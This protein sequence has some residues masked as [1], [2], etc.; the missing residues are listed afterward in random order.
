ML[1]V[2]WWNVAGGVANCRRSAFLASPA[3]GISHWGK[4]A[5]QVRTFFQTC[6]VWGCDVRHFGWS[7]ATVRGVT[8]YGLVSVGVAFLP[9]LEFISVLG[10]AVGVDG[11]FAFL[12]KALPP[13]G[14]AGIED[15]ALIFFLT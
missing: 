3:T 5:S 2:A 10:Y 9:L 12:V 15:E 13:A 6:D 14:A 4:K 11:L 8:C 7:P 1:Q